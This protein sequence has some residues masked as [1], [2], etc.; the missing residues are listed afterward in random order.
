[1]AFEFAVTLFS[2]SIVLSQVHFVFYRKWT[3]ELWK[4]L[5]FPPF[6]F[7]L[8]STYFKNGGYWLNKTVCVF[9]RHAH[10]CNCQLRQDLYIIPC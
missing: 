6:V 7:V 3:S 2:F 9:G 10:Y 1:M 5:Y 4:V 8:H